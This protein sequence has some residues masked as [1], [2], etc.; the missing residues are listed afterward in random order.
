MT[1]T[2]VGPREDAFTDND[3]RDGRHSAEPATD[4]QMWE[5][6]YGERQRTNRPTN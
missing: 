2:P 3:G 5:A 6:A 4:E 1:A